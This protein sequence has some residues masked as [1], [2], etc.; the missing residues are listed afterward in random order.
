MGELRWDCERIHD[1]HRRR[2][3]LCGFNYIP[4]HAVNTT[5]QW[6]DFDPVAVDR[7][8]AWAGHCGLNACRVFLQYLVWRH[9]PDERSRRFERFLAI[10]AAHGISVMPVL[11]DDCHFGELRDPAL[12]PQ[13]AP[14]PGR[15]ASGW[16]PSPGP[17]LADEPAEW[18]RLERYVHDVI[19]R[20]RADPRVALW[21]VYNEPGNSERRDRALPL[22]RGAFAWARAVR[23]EQPLTAAPWAFGPDWS[24]L[25]RVLVDNSDLPSFHS[26][27]P[28]DETSALVD[29]LGGDRP[30]LCSEWMA[31]SLGSRIGS[32]LPWFAEHGVHSFLWGLVNG[33]TQTHLG[34]S[35]SDPMREPEEWFCDLLRPDGTPYR[36]DEIEVIRFCR[37]RGRSTASAAG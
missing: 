21:D 37:G 1:W 24:T 4:A 28:L 15:Q 20:H 10:A 9:D 11:F 18:P 32:H 6:L 14:I 25:N 27:S 23:P 26:Y 30:V 3:W 12:G 17:G 7:E 13:P 35:W 22:V 8:L 36:V 19:G 31:R 2:G 16:T 29:R 34:W 5:E 33:R